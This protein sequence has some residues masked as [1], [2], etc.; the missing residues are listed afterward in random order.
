[1]ENID[2]NADILTILDGYKSYAAEYEE[3]KKKEEE[4]QK[5]KS[6]EEKRIIEENLKKKSIQEEIAD[7]LKKIKEQEA[8]DAKVIIAYLVHLVLKKLILFLSTLEGF[9]F[10]WIAKWLSFD[11]QLN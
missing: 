10:W 4:E 6:A 3:R 11:I 8:E 2:K 1:M 7:T 9:P 5:R